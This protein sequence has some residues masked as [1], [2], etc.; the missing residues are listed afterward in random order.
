[1]FE[2]IGRLAERAAGNVSL[3]RRGFLGQLG[4]AALVAAGA[5]GGLLALPR[6]ASATSKTLY[7]CGCFNYTGISWYECGGCSWGA[8]NCGT[9][10]K[11]KTAIGTC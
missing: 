4:Q 1:M 2:K 9:G 3:S 7:A 8:H 5:V 6:P 10:R 11:G